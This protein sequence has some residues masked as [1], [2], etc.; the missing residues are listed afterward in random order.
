MGIGTIQNDVR[1]EGRGG[2]MPKAYE[3]VQGVGVLLKAYVRFTLA[4]LEGHAM[5]LSSAD[6]EVPLLT[7]IVVI[8]I[9]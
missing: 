6:L 5:A 2:V 3:R 1:S 4:G 9:P 8:Y 7:I